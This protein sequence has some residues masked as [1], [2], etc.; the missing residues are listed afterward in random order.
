MAWVKGFFLPIGLIFSLLI[1]GCAA[2]NGQSRRDNFSPLFFNQA[3]QKETKQEVDAIGPFYSAYSNPKEEGWAVRPLLSYHH[4]REKETKEW[5]FLYPLGKYRLTPE[6]RYTHFIPL[7]RGA[8][9]LKEKP[10]DGKREDFGFFPVF[11]GKTQGGESYGGLFPV[12]GQ[13]KERFGRDEI[14]FFLWPLYST[15]RWEGNKKT[16]ILWPILSWTKGDEEQ[17]FRLWPLYGYEKKRGEYDRSF[18]LWPFFFHYRED[19]DTDAPKTKWMLFPLYIS[20]TS[21]IENKKIILWPFFNYYHDRRNDY[22]QWDMPWPFIQYAKSEDYNVKKFWPIFSEKRK[23]ASYE[24]SLLWPVYEYSKENMEEDQAEK[25]TYRFL[26]I[27]KSETT[28]WPEKKEEESIAR[29]WP[30]FYLKTRR[31][32]SAF[33]H[34]PA[35]I[36]LEDEGFERNYGPIFRLYEYEKDKEGG[37]KSKLLWG[38]YRHEIKGDWSLVELSCLLSWESGADMTRL[39][40][41]EGLF[42]YLRRKAQKAIKL[43]YVPDVVTWGE[44][45]PI[46]RSE[47]QNTSA[48][49]LREQ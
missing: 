1:T 35:I 6:E 49:D 21:D 2:F 34:F 23:P 31:D 32:G 41:A 45:V 22:T 48:P 42:E 7:V 30:L 10:E 37:E 47:S 16:T 14:T 12:Y 26:I 46:P 5:Q 20:E 44:R 8:K 28:V 9:P 29:L 43:F 40:V 17:A 33:L 19:L 13:F 39:T 18:V 3:D 11:W 36:P 15:A 4:D 27:N 25:T 24:F 38:L